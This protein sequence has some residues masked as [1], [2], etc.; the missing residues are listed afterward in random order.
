MVYTGCRMV[1]TCLV[2]VCALVEQGPLHFPSPAQVALSPEVQDF[3]R[4]LLERDPSVRLG[5]DS[6]YDAGFDTSWNTTVGHV[7]K[8]ANAALVG[9]RRFASGGRPQDL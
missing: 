2:H 1:F 5:D 4:Q 7:I 3:I 9:S 8:H 6:T